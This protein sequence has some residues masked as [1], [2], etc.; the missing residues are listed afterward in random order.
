[1]ETFRRELKNLRLGSSIII[2][3]NTDVKETEFQE[4]KMYHYNV[5][6]LRARNHTENILV[7]DFTQ[8]KGL[9]NFRWGRV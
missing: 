7:A 8:R 5:V 6:N 9:R 1:M 2:N 4:F 3:V